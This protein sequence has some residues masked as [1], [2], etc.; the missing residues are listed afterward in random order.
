MHDASSE[1]RAASSEMRAARSEKLGDPADHPAPLALGGS[2]PDAISLTSLDCIVE[3]FLPYRASG[4]DSEA[5]RRIVVGGRKEH[6]RVLSPT[7]G[8]SRPGPV[9]IWVHERGHLILHTVYMTYRRGKWFPLCEP[10]GFGRRSTVNGQQPKPGPQA[11]VGEYDSPVSSPDGRGRAEPVRGKSGLHR[12]ECWVTPRRG[13]PTESA[14][15][16][17]PPTLPS[18]SRQG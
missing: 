4:T 2:A 3:A 6:R 18:G 12:E 5:K 13:N 10:F 11:E 14:T 7:L 1:Q 16:N 8:A 9:L 17:R 15:E